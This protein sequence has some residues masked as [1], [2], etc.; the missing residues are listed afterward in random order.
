MS[1]AVLLV[2]LAAVTLTTAL[3]GFS[4]AVFTDRKTNP[5]TLKA[6]STWPTPTPTATP[7]PTPTPTPPPGTGL[8]ARYRNNT[9][10]FPNDNA[11]TPWLQLVNTTTAT[12]DLAPAKMRYWFT[13]EPAG[14]GLNVYCDYAWLGCGNLTYAAL[15]FSPVKPLANTYVEVGFKPGLS[16]KA[17]ENSFDIQLRVHKS[18]W[19]NFDETN[20]YSYGTDPNFLDWP[21][22]GVYYNGVLVWG[23]P[24]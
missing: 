7:T 14:A 22:V 1:R 15:P 23:T 13:N 20:D 11:I 12:I 19:S 21:K 10:T 16:L 6:A 3:S 2:A 4:G 9:P 8:K 24:P 17:G 5:Q 18:D